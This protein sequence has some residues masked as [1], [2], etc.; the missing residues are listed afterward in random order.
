M[1]VKRYF[2]ILNE[3]LHRTLARQKSPDCCARNRAGRDLT[4]PIDGESL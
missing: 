3:L 4:G 2:D 1:V